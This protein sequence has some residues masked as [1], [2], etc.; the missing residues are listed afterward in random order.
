M[1]R[2]LSRDPIQEEGGWN[3]YAFAENAPV[4]FIDKS[5]MFSFF[6]VRGPDFDVSPN[7][8]CCLEEKPL[9]KA[10]GYG[11]LSE[12]MQDNTNSTKYFGMTCSAL[13]AVKNHLMKIAIGALYTGAL[14][15]D[16]LGMN[17]ICRK[18]ICTK[19]KS[20]VKNIRRVRRPSGLVRYVYWSCPDKTGRG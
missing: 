12:C 4:V 9:W 8:S 18:M 7:A 16:I 14:V 17:L 6:P 15:G 3:L 5:G 2:F 10:S 11:S 20:P 1:G 19:I 13:C